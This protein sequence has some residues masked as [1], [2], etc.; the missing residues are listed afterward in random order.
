MNEALRLYPVV[1]VNARTANKDTTIPRGGG[2]DGKSKIFIP[3]VTQVD[4]SV[5]AMHRRHNIWGPDAEEFIPERWEGRKVG[6]EYLPLCIYPINSH[7]IAL[8]F[9]PY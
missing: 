1:A 9:T 6:W 7:R 2:P 5:H 4:Y 8:F 3:K